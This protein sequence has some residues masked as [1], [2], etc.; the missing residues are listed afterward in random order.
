MSAPLPVRIVGGGLAGLSLGIALGRAGVPVTIYEAGDYPRHRVCGEFVAGLD[1]ATIARL[2]IG[3][4]FRGACLHREVTW[5]LHERIVA[6]HALPAPARAISRFVLDARLAEL[7]TAGGGRLLTRARQV[8]PPDDPGWVDA[9]GRK[10]SGSSPWLGLKLHARDLASSAGLEVHLGDRAYVGLSAV[11]DGW[12]NVCGLFRRRAGLHVERDRALTTYLRA[13][14][15]GPL[16]ERLE[17]ATIRPDSASAVAGFAFAR[18]VVDDGGLHLGDAGGAIP[19]FT[20]NGMAMSFTGAA[21]ALDPLVGWSQGGCDWTATT[22]CI[23]DSLHAAF[24]RRLRGAALLHPF[25]LRGP[26]QLLLGA[27]ARTGLLPT[28]LLYRLLH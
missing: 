2:G 22:H 3:D 13:S 19:P 12:T 9:G 6:R 11:E 7:F 25:L 8:L 16:A 5:F 20:G 10:P 15:L 14:G 1:D 24:D 28:V 21:L 4:V 17:A 26:L 27:S 23:R 18:R